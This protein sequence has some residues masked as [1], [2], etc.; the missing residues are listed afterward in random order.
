M[1]DIE[2]DEVKKSKFNNIKK[3][4]YFLVRLIL[5]NTVKNKLTSAASGVFILLNVLN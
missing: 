3:P 5:Y 4:S 1:D 2:T